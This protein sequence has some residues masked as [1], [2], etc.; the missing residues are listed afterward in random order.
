[1]PKFDIDELAKHVLNGRE[2]KN[3]IRLAMALAAEEEEETG[4]ATPLSQKYILET[5]DI[6][7]D[8]NDKMNSAEA[9]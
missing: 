8:F 3:A 5:V 1:M 9:Y 7:N 4:I 2:I 6:L